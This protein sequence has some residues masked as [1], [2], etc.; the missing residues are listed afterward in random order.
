MQTVPGG[1]AGI[2]YGIYSVRV[3]MLEV[4]ATLSCSHAVGMAVVL[5]VSVSSKRCCRCRSG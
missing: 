3:Q 2:T 5:Q 4:L 1:C